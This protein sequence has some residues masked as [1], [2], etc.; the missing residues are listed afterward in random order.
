[1]LLAAA[2]VCLGCGDDL[3]GPEGETSSESSAAKVPVID[4]ASI[5]YSASLRVITF[6]ASCPE[7]TYTKVLFRQLTNGTTER[8]ADVTYNTTSST[9]FSRVPTLT[10]GSDYAFCIIG[11]DK[12]GQEVVRTAERTFSLPKDAAPEAPSTAS[13]KA[14][15][16]S[17][18]NA[19]DGYIK[20][21]GISTAME[22]STDSGKTWTPVAYP[23]IISNLPPGPVLLRLAETPTTEAGR[24]ATIT[25]PPYKS[26]IDIDGSDGHSEGLH[27]R[28]PTPRET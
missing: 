5:N 11:Y 28:R 4:E 3:P 6:K 8:M 17:S 21:D 18:A 19:T 12:D 27:I 9:Y 7:R 15:A 10:G 20:G 13:I 26:N 1:M 2:V 16:P 23:G 22:Y 24:T 14:Y 25:V